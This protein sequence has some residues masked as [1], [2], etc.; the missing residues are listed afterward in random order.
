VIIPYEQLSKDAL[1]AVIEDWLSRQSQD[2]AVSFESREKLIEQVY[3]ELKASRLVV[4]W[5]DE[6]QTI[7][8]LDKDSLQNVHQ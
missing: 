3:R 4:T 7:N 2:L 1:T 5:D 8:L 6:T